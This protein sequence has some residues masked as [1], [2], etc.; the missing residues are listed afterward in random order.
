MN[1]PEKLATY[2]TYDEDKNNRRR[3][4]NTMVSRKRKKGQ[5]M[6]YTEN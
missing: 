1:N 5:A 3:T 2:G 6:I 4:G